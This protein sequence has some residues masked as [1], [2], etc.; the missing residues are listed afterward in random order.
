[1]AAT[2]GVRAG[3]VIAVGAGLGVVV[4]VSVG[5]GKAETTASWTIDPRSGVGVDPP[6]AAAT[7][8]NVAKATSG[9]VLMS[10]NCTSGIPAGITTRRCT[11]SGASY[12]NP[13]GNST[14]MRRASRS[15]L[16]MTSSSDG[17]SIS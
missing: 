11:P 7:K 2:S 16:W 15:T 12:R 1:M 3:V 13:S 8:S 10:S 5:E 17:I 14:T 4:G 9:R 6:Q